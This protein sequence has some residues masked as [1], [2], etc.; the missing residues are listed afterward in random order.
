VGPVVVLLKVDDRLDVVDSGRLTVSKGEPS[1]VS[2]L[3]GKDVLIGVDTLRY[4]SG[5]PTCKCDVSVGARANL[6][7]ARSWAKLKS[8]S[9]MKKGWFR[10]TRSG[11]EVDVRKGEGDEDTMDSLLLFR[12]TEGIRNKSIIMIAVTNHESRSAEQFNQALKRV[13]DS[14]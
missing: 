12:L 9:G 6:D 5:L 13:T 4:W 14:A 10:L 11:S 7:F 3:S 1:T 8:S 2:S